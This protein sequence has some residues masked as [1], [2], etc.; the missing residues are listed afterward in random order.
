MA[1]WASRYRQI[2]TIFICNQASYANGTRL[3]ILLLQIW[4]PEENVA[5]CLF[6]VNN[7]NFIVNQFQFER[8]SEDTAEQRA[9]I[10]RI[11]LDILNN[12][13]NKSYGENIR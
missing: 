2:D 11:T 13:V 4:G 9:D 5:K 10:R 6:E 8:D 3:S 1:S 12:C 7:L